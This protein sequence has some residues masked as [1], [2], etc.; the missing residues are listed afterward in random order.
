MNNDQLKSVIEKLLKAGDYGSLTEAETAVLKRFARPE[1]VHIPDDEKRPLWH[2]IHDRYY[3]WSLLYDTR[4]PFLRFFHGYLKPYGHDACTDIAVWSAGMTLREFTGLIKDNI[5]SYDTYDFLHIPEMAGL[6]GLNGLKEAI[7]HHIRSGEY[8]QSPNPDGYLESCIK[9]MVYLD[10]DENAELFWPYRN[11]SN[12]VI[13]VWIKAYYEKHPDT[14]TPDKI[15]QLVQD[16]P[17]PYIL[18]R[19]PGL[20]LEAIR[21]GFDAETFLKCV[22]LCEYHGPYNIYIYISLLIRTRKFILPNHSGYPLYD[23]FIA[24]L[25]VQSCFSGE[26]WLYD[27]LTGLIDTAENFTETQALLTAA[28]FTLKA[29]EPELI[30]RRLQPENTTFIPII[31]WGLIPHPSA[32]EKINAF[33]G[34]Q[35]QD[36]HNNAVTILRLIRGAEPA[37]VELRISGILKKHSYPFYRVIKQALRFLKYDLPDVIR[38]YDHIFSFE[39]HDDAVDYFKNRPYRLIQWLNPMSKTFYKQ[40]WFF[41]RAVY[42]AGKTGSESLRVHLEQMLLQDLEYADY[43]DIFLE[44]MV[45][46]GPETVYGKLLKRILE[47]K[48]SQVIE[49]EPEEVF[50]SLLFLRHK[51]DCIRNV[52]IPSLINSATLSGELLALLAGNEK[53]PNLADVI[54]KKAGTLTTDIPTLPDEIRT[55]LKSDRIRAGDYILLDGLVQNGSP[56]LRA[57]IAALLPESGLSRD[58]LLDYLLLLASDDKPEV[59]YSALKS[60]AHMEEHRGWLLTY[61]TD[62]INGR[63]EYMKTSTDEIRRF[64]ECLGHLAGP[65]SLIQISRIMERTDIH[66]QKGVCY[67]TLRSLMRSHPQYR[68][69]VWALDDADRIDQEYFLYSRPPYATNKREQCLNLMSTALQKTARPDAVKTHLGKKLIIEMLNESSFAYNTDLLLTMDEFESL[70]VHLQVIWHEGSI[71]AEVTTEKSVQILN[72]V[73]QDRGY[74]VFTARWV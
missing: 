11:H 33:T 22:L 65:G 5:Q 14:L 71:A 23:Q 35:N 51:D 45:L 36:I 53:D 8:T 17:D 1:T 40:K 38:E 46:G 20:L 41:S 58:R 4:M 15:H 61:I 13:R 47:C 6:A 31:L 52:L 12:H 62:I 24:E 59:A 39:F 73:F 74:A 70:A 57:K 9:A 68:F 63:M 56:A 27:H 19:V 72:A 21:Q 29:P 55:I 3:K 48:G 64:T 18:L 49:P 16:E 67:L 25:A 50:Y 37:E 44:L 43:F 34:D 32:H 30:D 42:Y 2:W 28:A 69:I 66:W 26:E 60:I 7:I 10:A 54:V